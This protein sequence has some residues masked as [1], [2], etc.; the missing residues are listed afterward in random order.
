LENDVRLH[1]NTY[2]RVAKNPLKFALLRV[3]IFQEL[4]SCSYRGHKVMILTTS[5]PYIFRCSLLEPQYDKGNK[6]HRNE[7]EEMDETSERVGADHS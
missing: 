1:G 4:E 6:H 2:P 7:E 3:L 5:L